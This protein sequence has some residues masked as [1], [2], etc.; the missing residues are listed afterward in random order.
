[1]YICSVEFNTVMNAIL[2]AV[3]MIIG[4]VTFSYIMGSLS[5]KGYGNVHLFGEFLQ[6][7]RQ[8]VWKVFYP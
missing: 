8:F 1:M 6:S 4:L 3:N 2:I 5:A 7:S